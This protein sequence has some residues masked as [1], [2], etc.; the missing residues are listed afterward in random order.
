MEHFLDE[1]EYIVRIIDIAFHDMARLS[2]SSSVAGVDDHLLDFRCH[3]PGDG[4]HFQVV[5]LPCPRSLGKILLDLAVHHMILELCITDPP[6]VR[7]I[8]EGVLKD[9]QVHMVHMEKQAAQHS[10]AGQI[11]SQMYPDACGT[12]FA[13]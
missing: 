11:S 5:F 13:P 6:V 4:E 7:R 10:S 3:P 12:G 2:S 9:A 1:I 8:C